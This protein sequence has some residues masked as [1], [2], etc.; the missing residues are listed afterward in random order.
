MLW[1]YCGGCAALEPWQLAMNEGNMNCA[2]NQVFSLRVAAQVQ[3]KVSKL[4]IT[5]S[6]KSE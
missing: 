4:V 6:V 1:G 3:L 5:K 2:H